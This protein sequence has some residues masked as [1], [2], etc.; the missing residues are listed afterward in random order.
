MSKGAKVHIII[1]DAKDGIRN[2]KFL[3]VSDRETCMGQVIP[4]NQ[5][6]RLQQRCDK[7][8]ELFKKDK[9]HYR[10]ALFI[11]LDS[12]SESK[13]IDVFSI[14]TTEVPR[15]NIWQT[16]YKMFST[17]NTTSTNLSGV[18]PAPCPHVTCS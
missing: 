10:R 6:K 2:D 12:R 16:R 1:Q 3:D 5:V 7:I 14:I 13:Q 8:N 15:A 9:E 4:L 11:H 17:G 18:F